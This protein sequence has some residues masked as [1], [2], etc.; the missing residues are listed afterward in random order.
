MSLDCEVNWKKVHACRRACGAVPLHHAPWEGLMERLLSRGFVFIGG[1]PLEWQRDS[2]MSPVIN[3]L[4]R[5]VFTRASEGI[6][7]LSIHCG[8]TPRS[9][10]WINQS[11]A[12]RSPAPPTAYP[13]PRPP[14]TQNLPALPLQCC[15]KPGSGLLW[16]RGGEKKKIMFFVCLF[17]C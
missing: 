5:H 1:A 8:V 10:K 12:L 4:G 17:F 13:P 9:Q 11:S 2:E 14:T 15:W 3:G 7:V 6:S 16:C